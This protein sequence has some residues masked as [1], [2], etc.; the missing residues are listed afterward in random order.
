[1]KKIAYAILILV[2][3]AVVAFMVSCSAEKPTEPQLST[4]EGSNSASFNKE[5]TCGTTIWDL[6][7]GQTIDVGSITVENDADNIYVTYT[8]DY[9]NPDCMID[10][11]NDGIPDALDPAIDAEFGTLHIWIGNDLTLIDGGGTSR[12]SPG[13]MAQQDGGA[14]YDA[15]GLTEYTFVIPWDQVSLVGVEDVC[16]ADLELYVVTHAEVDLKDCDGNTTDE[17]TAYGGPVDPNTPGAWWYYGLYTVCCDFGPP[18]PPFCETAFAKGGYVWTTMKKSN[19]ENLPSLELTRN[20][21]GWAIELTETGE[22]SYDIWAG[23][24]LN[25]TNKG[26]LVGTLTV[27]WD[28]A[29]ASVTYNMSTGYCLEEAHLY[30][31]DDSPTTIAPGQYGN[32]VEF[33]PNAASYTFNVAL[34][35]DTGDGNVWL[36]A[37]AVVC[38]ECP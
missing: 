10:T 25:D 11:D 38:N 19:P 27:N 3:V 14:Q 8:L 2:T 24:G 37:H 5:G 18:Q 7:A 12:P 22:S 16:N 13:Q 28:G 20:R 36:V 33:D 17:E 31:G 29:K 6:R 30:A 9:Q 23:A 32:I 21:W 26:V 1:M 15:T 34:S 35:N 4:P